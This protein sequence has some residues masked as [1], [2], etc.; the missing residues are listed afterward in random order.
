MD[1]RRQVFGNISGERLR[2]SVTYEEV[3]LHDQMNVGEGLFRLGRYSPFYNFGRPH[4]ALDYRPS[5]E[6]NF[7][8]PFGVLFRI[9]RRG[10]RTLKLPPCPVY[11]EARRTCWPSTSPS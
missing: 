6:A 11:S 5:H 1:V 4:Q 10:A 7:A 3:F 8:A 9:D 2:Q